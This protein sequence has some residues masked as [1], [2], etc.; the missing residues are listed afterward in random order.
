[1]KC[2]RG[3]VIVLYLFIIDTN[4]WVADVILRTTIIAVSRSRS[5]GRDTLV[6]GRQSSYLMDMQKVRETQNNQSV[7]FRRTTC[8]H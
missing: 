6:L 2:F 5:S 7:C 8:V 4:E 3:Y 1:M